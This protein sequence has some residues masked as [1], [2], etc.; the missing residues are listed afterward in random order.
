MFSK[1]K[2]QRDAVVSGG[3][4]EPLSWVSSPIL[5]FLANNYLTPT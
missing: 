2:Y 1:E 5:G 3:W 4:H